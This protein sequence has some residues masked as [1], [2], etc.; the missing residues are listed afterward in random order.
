[1]EEPGDEI[2][3]R[4]K[5]PSGNPR[6]PDLNFTS[7]GSAEGTLGSHFHLT[8]PTTQPPEVARHHVVA[9]GRGWGERPPQ[10]ALAAGFA[11][12]NEGGRRGPAW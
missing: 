12:S 6:P 4:L 10:R 11:Q 9:R 7:T 2:K 1:M 5:T 3:W 8:L